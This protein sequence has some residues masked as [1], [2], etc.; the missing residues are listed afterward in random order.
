MP[1]LAMIGTIIGW[2][3]VLWTIFVSSLLG[4]VVGIYYRIKRGDQV[5]PF[6]PYL[7]MAGFIALIWGRPI[8]ETYL[9]GFQ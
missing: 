7:A 3:G 1:S 5:I 8:M 6:G 4:S 9:R 2:Q